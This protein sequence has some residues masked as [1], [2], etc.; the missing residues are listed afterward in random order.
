MSKGSVW[1][2]TPEGK[3]IRR[4]SIATYWHSRPVELMESPALRVLSRAAHLALLR[5]ELELR[6]HAG[7]CNGKLT[8]T[9]DQFIEYGLAKKSVASAL[10]ELAALGIIIITERGRGGNAQYASS[11]KFLLNYQCGAIDCVD[12]HSR[13]WKRF[14]TLEEAERVALAARKAKDPHKVADGR[15]RASSQKHF[16]GPERGLVPDPKGDLETTHPQAPKGVY[17]PRPQKGSTIDTRVGGGGGDGASLPEPVSHTPTAPSEAAADARPVPDERPASD[18]ASERA[19]MARRSEQA[20]HDLT[21]A[22]PNEIT[23]ADQLYLKRRWELNGA[24]R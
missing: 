18:P 21:V 1:K 5:I 9:K 8:V 4:N 17:R 2:N 14:E 24:H 20:G 16:P 7:R 11:H 23:P 12:D 3:T 10:R 15:R 13:R 22:D 19:L 6:Q